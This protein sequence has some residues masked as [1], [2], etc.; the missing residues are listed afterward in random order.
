MPGAKIFL[1]GTRTGVSSWKASV[2]EKSLEKERAV[3]PNSPIRLNVAAK[4]AYPDG[5]MT[6]SGLRREAAR[7]RLVIERTAGKDY[8]TLA[9]IEQMRALCR[10]VPKDRDCG[11]NLRAE[12]P[13]A[14]SFETHSTSFETD[15]SNAALELA[16][17]KLKKLREN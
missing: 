10:V 15:Q 9:H 5:S 16:K 6:A 4:L 7:G 13:A 14:M 17:A 11:S 8:T 1:R 3:G 2:M 12:I